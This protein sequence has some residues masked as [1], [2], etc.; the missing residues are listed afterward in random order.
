MKGRVLIIAGSDSSGGAG[1]QADVKTVTA[2]GGYAMTAITAVTAQNTLGVSAIH[3]LPPEIVSGQIKA[4]L[5]DIGADI[6]KIGMIGDLASADVIEAALSDWSEIPVVLDPVL[7]ATSGDT[8]SGESVA[9]FMK[10]KLIPR[11]FLITPNIPEAE[12][13]TGINMSDPAS[14]QSTAEKILGFGAQ[15][16]LLKDGH[17][18]DAILQDTLY[19][20][21]KEIT[22]ESPRLETRHTHGTGCTLASG[23]STFLAQ[24]VALEVAVEQGLAYTAEAIRTAPGLGKGHGPLNH[25]HTVE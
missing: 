23:I 11:S 6:I 7:V 13:L 14:R 10:Q 12:M 8:L 2:L 22:F 18:K 9:T 16:V 25:S 17:G 4:C 15:S 5:E 1:V 24:G 21:E 19:T 3:Q 20:L